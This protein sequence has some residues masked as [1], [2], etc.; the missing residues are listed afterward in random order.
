VDTSSLLALRQR[1]DAAL[2]AESPAA[3]D[4]L[5]AGV[6]EA[7][8]SLRPAP[9]PAVAPEARL[10]RTVQVLTAVLA[11]NSLPATLPDDLQFDE[12]LADL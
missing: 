9:D 11:A 10:A 12:A 1:I 2:A 3:A 6:A 8:R 5:A 4:A 7:L